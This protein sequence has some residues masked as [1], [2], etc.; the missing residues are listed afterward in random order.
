MNNALRLSL[1]ASKTVHLLGRFKA[2]TLHLGRGQPSC[3]FAS[4]V[5]ASCI[6]HRSRQASQ[7]D[8]IF[9]CKPRSLAMHHRR[10]NGSVASPKTSDSNSKWYRAYIALGSNVGDRVEMIEQACDALNQDPDMV[11]KRTSCLYETEPMYV[12]DQARFLN[13][14][15][16]VGISP[17]ACRCISE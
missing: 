5:A 15:C 1:G 4:P 9:D 12:E 14:A 6:Q 10:F 8:L 13:G 3:R 2:R 16:E 7:P 11:V 17:P